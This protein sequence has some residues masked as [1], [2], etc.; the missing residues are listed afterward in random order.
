MRKEDEQKEQ[1]KN[2]FKF[3]FV[4]FALSLL[5]FC[6]DVL[7]FLGRRLQIF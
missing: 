7:I 4:F 3:S 5:F 6:F 2:S 1:K